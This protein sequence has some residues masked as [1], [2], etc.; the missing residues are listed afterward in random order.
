MMW[1]LCLGYIANPVDII[2]IPLLKSETE[3]GEGK[4]DSASVVCGERRF[5]GTATSET[6][7]TVKE[8]V[9]TVGDSL[10]IED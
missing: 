9:Y 1:L 8:I 4:H 7:V 10:S 5:Q 2:I 6:S 3:K